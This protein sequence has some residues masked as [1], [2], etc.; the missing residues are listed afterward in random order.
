MKA[1]FW[2]LSPLQKEKKQNRIKDLVDESLINATAVY[3]YNTLQLN[4]D[5]WQTTLQAQQKNIIQNVYSKRLSS[6]LS[7]SVAAAV[8]KE[9]NNGRLSQ[10][11]TGSDFAFL[12]LRAISL[13]KTWR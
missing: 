2:F 9:A 1:R 12:M 10:Y 7:D 13:V 4:K 8:I 6:Q 3:L 11:F 5:N